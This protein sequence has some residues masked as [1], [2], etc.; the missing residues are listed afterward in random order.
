M[1][2]ALE[3]IRILSIYAYFVLTVAALA[4][5]GMVAG[6]ALVVLWECRADRSHIPRQTLTSCAQVLRCGEDICPVATTESEHFV[7]IGERKLEEPNRSETTGGDN[8]EPCFVGS[9]F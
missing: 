6:I 7:G 2:T 8:D 1:N 5:T 3:I 4:L 9:R